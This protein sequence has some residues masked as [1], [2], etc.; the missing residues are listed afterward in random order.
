[1][2]LNFKKHKKLYFSLKDAYKMLKQI[3]IF[4]PNKNNMG[5]MNYIGTLIN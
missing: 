4:A 2:L 3:K 1:M 5:Q